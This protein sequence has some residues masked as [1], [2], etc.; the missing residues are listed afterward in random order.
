MSSNGRTIWRA[1]VLLLATLGASAL[2]PSA[3]ASVTQFAVGS[4]TP[5][6]S[7]PGAGGTVY[8]WSNGVFRR[9]PP[10]GFN[11]ATATPA[12][13]QWYGVLPDTPN[14]SNV[15]IPP[16][17]GP[18]ESNV[19][20]VEPPGTWQAQKAPNW[21]GPQPITSGAWSVLDQ[22]RQLVP[23]VTPYSLSDP[24]RNWTEGEEDSQWAGMGEG[25]SS[26]WLLQTGTYTYWTPQ[27][28]VQ[29]VNGEPFY[30][31]WP[32]TFFIDSTAPAA[33][34]GQTIDASVLDWGLD[35]STGDETVEF[36]VYNVTT[37][38]KYEY[39]DDT[40]IPPGSY[41]PDENEAILEHEVDGTTYGL[42]TVDFGTNTAPQTD[43]YPLPV[44]NYSYVSFDNFS[45][46]LWGAWNKNDTVQDIKSSVPGA[47]GQTVWTFLNCN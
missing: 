4:A 32:I 2:A 11:F 27:G 45:G 47:N 38:F 1:T 43:V 14:L 25:S 33:L 18:L 30:A 37:G 20:G 34:P 12:Q 41:N 39:I 15:T 7:G 9:V 44:G 28:K 8:T 29:G 21:S 31:Y 5:V 3:L 24:C 23:H 10:A 35:S 6:T 42:S 26:D 19:P 46:Y 40:H 36:S 17:S 22:Y 13:L 16:P